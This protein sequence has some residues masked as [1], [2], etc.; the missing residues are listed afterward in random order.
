MHLNNY[1]AALESNTIVDILKLA[2]L[3]VTRSDVRVMSRQ[4]QSLLHADVHQG[5]RLGE[6]LR[7]RDDWKEQLGLQAVMQR[8]PWDRCDREAPAAV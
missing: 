2:P 1:E 3:R 8:D 7:A 5:R 4:G 6:A